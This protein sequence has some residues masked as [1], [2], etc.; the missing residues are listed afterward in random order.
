[1]ANQY[2]ADN[3][4]V[5]TISLGHMKNAQWAQRWQAQFAHMTLDE[6]YAGQGE[7]IPLKRL[8]EAEDVADFVCF[9]ASERARYT[10]GAAITIDGGLSGAI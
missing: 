2:A 3:I 5:N 9:L 7:P 1:L 10:T 4:L 8:G 6:F